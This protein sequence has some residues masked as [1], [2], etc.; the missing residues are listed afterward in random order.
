MK[1][2]TEAK[3]VIATDEELEKKKLNHVHKKKAKRAHRHAVHHKKKTAKEG[4]DDDE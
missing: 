3:L 4:S 2:E 1:E